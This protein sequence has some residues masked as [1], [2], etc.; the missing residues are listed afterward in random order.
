VHQ[1]CQLLGKVTK[2]SDT[3]D[4]VTTAGRAKES[5]YQVLLKGLEVRRDLEATLFLNRIKSTT[6][7]REFAGL[8]TWIVNIDGGT[9]PTGDGSDL[10][11]PKTSA[12]L[13]L[14]QIDTVMQACYE[15]GGSP[16][17]MYLSPKVK[18][19][20]SALS[21][22]AE[23]RVNQTTPGAPQ[24]AVTIG[25][26][27]VYLSDFGKLETVIDRFMPVDEMYLIDQ[28][29]IEMGNLPGRAWKQTPLAKIGSSERAMI[30]FE[31]APKVLANAAH[32]MILGIS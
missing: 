16:H 14:N 29:Y 28:D 21:G 23:N 19:D 25:S 8:P 30:E 18:R 24:D 9:A 32:G 26:V 15:A 2:V 27:S 6:D 5:A 31:G 10:A 4:A 1:V 20:F 13:T 22:I 3:G 7:P 12:P 17:N 11:V